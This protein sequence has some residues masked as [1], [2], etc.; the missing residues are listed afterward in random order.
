MR[1][2]KEMKEKGLPDGYEDVLKQ[3]VDRDRQDMNREVEPL[4]Q[5]EDAVLLDSTNLSFDQVVERILELVEA[6]GNGR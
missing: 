6:N 2:W 4:R 3:V 1:R 5:A